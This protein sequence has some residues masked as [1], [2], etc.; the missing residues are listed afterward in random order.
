[1]QNQPVL[2]F[3]TRTCSNPSNKI[4]LFH[5]VSCDW[6]TA[7]I[8]QCTGQQAF[9]YTFINQLNHTYQICLISLTSR[10]YATSPL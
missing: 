8:P 3:E 6:L 5:I 10:H 2:L 9:V 1:M 4:R 7:F